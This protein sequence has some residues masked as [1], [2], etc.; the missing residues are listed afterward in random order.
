MDAWTPPA[1]NAAP[2]ATPSPAA[3]NLYENI[4][5]LKLDVSSLVPLHGRV[6]TLTDFATAI[7]KPRPS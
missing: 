2:P 3:L 1:P 5:R 7:G 6:M 4:Q